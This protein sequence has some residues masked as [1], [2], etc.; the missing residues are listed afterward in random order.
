MYETEADIREER[1]RRLAYLAFAISML[2]SVAICGGILFVVLVPAEGR[3][4]VGAEA[5]FAV[6]EIEEVAVKRLELTELLPNKP[7]WSE[8]IVFVIK[9]GDNT[10]RAFLGLDPLSGCKLNWRQEVFVDDCT[11]TR[12]T[13]GGRNE[14]LVMTLSGP[15]NQQQS[16]QMIEL[17]VA[18]ES[19]NVYVID[20]ILRRDL[21]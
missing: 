6:G 5:A 20:R 4:L 1:S 12:Y 16:A 9:Q 15:A 2:L 21:R 13:I 18:I 3:R 17:P 10:Y 19:G 7:N 11:N 8:D 14:A